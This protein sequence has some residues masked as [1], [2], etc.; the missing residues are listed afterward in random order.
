MK[1]EV[2]K[3]DE[4]DC[5]EDELQEEKL[6]LEEKIKELENDLESREEELNDTISTLES[7]KDDITG[8]ITGQKEFFEGIDEQLTLKE[9]KEKVR[10]QRAGMGSWED[11]WDVV[12]AVLDALANVITEP[13]A[14]LRDLKK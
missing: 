4:H 14:A 9:L 12:T 5:Q 1:K 2:I 10:K 3:D 13:E 11:D 6:K 8:S 7:E